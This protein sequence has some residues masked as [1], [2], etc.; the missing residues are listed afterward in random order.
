MGGSHQG[1]C[2]ES[3]TGVIGLTASSFRAL[4]RVATSSFRAL[5]R[6]ATSRLRMRFSHF[7]VAF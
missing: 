6:V 4:S 7:R 5:S 3:E 2:S 1:N